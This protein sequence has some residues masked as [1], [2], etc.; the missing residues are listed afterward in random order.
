MQQLAKAHDCAQWAP[1]WRT[2]TDFKGG[3]FLPSNKSGSS[4]VRP[5][6]P[7]KIDAVFTQLASHPVPSTLCSGRSHRVD[8]LTAAP[9]A[10]SRGWRQPRRMRDELLWRDA[11]SQSTPPSQVAATL[12]LELDTSSET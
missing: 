8:V 7:T 1:S 2:L 5:S 9:P 12:L 4:A 11:T 6:A 3:F 10:R